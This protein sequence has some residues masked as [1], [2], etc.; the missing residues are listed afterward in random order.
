MLTWLR[1]GEVKRE[2]REHNKPMSLHL[3]PP[4]DPI[5]AFTKAISSNAYPGATLAFVGLR[6]GRVIR[7]IAGRLVLCAAHPGAEWEFS[8]DIDDLAIRRSW[9]PR[10][11]VGAVL[12]NLRTTE[13]TINSDR[14]ALTRDAGAG[15]HWTRLSASART[16]EIIGWRADSLV[17]QGES[18]YLQIGYETYTRLDARMRVIGHRRFS[19]WDNLA[20]FLG[21][22]GTPL[23]LGD[24][25]NALFEC[26][27]PLY[28][29]FDS[30]TG[31]QADGTLAISV[32]CPLIPPPS[33]LQVLLESAGPAAP[34]P[35]ELNQV[36]GT[37]LWRH[38]LLLRPLVHGTRLTLML[39][40]AIA[41]T[42][43]LGVPA[44]NTVADVALSSQ[45]SGLGARHL[46]T[47]AI[48]ESTAPTLVDRW[49]RKAA[50]NP[51]LAILI[52]LVAALGATAGAIV[53]VESILSS[54]KQAST[55]SA[56]P[57][58]EVGVDS[59]LTPRP[60]QRLKAVLSSIRGYTSFR[61]ATASSDEA[62]RILSSAGVTR[63]ATA[64]GINPVTAQVDDQWCLTLWPG[65]YGHPNVYGVRYNP[66]TGN[67]RWDSQ[68]T[69]FEIVIPLHNQP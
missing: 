29:R 11:R 7:N 53:S 12:S 55:T 3:P 60:S 14:L 5:E 4:D 18:Q 51:F 57:A 61:S 2:S 16:K 34:I 8:D 50:N 30:N 45:S 46:G 28:A 66:C 69:Y 68:K 65:S 52:I 47:A 54:F 67:S 62:V 9:L 17:G 13:V 21:G 25:F 6:D 31:P 1:W 39:G 23:G 33:I 10:E 59:G 63:I 15:Y 36:P 26:F 49:R 35:L 41:D 44:A 27:A 19:G 42:F 37:D 40:T 58:A 38:S 24:R 43:V 48:P 32:R 56:G 64:T 20:A 22:V